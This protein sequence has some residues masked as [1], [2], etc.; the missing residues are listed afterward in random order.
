MTKHDIK[1]IDASTKS[2]IAYALQIEGET[3]GRIER[4]HGRDFWNGTVVGQDTLYRRD[5]FSACLEATC[6]AIKEARS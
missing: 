6:Q 2:K 3:V 4:E 5:R 1:T